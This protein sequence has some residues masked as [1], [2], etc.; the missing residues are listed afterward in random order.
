MLGNKSRYTFRNTTGSPINLA[1]TSGETIDGASSP[2]ALAAN[3]QATIVSEVT[4]AAG[5]TV[6]F[7]APPAGAVVGTTDTQTLAAKTLTAP[8]INGAVTGT[9]WRQ[10]NGFHAG[11]ARRASEP[12]GRRCSARVHD[13]G[14]DRRQ[15]R[16]DRRLHRNPGVHW[17][18]QPDVHPPDNEHPCGGADLRFST[19]V[20]AL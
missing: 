1:F 3:S 18:V 20:P 12:S 17:L 16:P 2:I 6:L 4:A 5:W 15:Y 11:C 7:F 9:G 13:S 14:G 10:L 19:V 8:V